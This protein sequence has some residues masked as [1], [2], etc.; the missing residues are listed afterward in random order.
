[1][2]PFA[3]HLWRPW[4]RVLQIKEQR[5][6]DEI[7]RDSLRR[8]IFYGGVIVAIYRVQLLGGSQIPTEALVHVDLGST[9]L[10]VNIIP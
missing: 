6:F 2:G 4:G 9:L 1:M 10:Q 8:K 7:G 5:P 3:L